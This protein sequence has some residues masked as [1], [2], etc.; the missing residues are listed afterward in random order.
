MRKNRKCTTQYTVFYV[1]TLKGEKT[2]VQQIFT[3]TMDIQDKEITTLF[4]QNVSTTQG[5]W[6]LLLHRYGT[7]HALASLF[8]TQSLTHNT[9]LYYVYIVMFALGVFILKYRDRQ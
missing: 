4:V 8:P 6:H 2:T 7:A 5:S 9:S 1:E 3:I